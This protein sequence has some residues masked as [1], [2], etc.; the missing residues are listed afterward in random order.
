MANLQQNNIS[1]TKIDPVMATALLDA[2]L[3]QNQTA[4]KLGV[5]PSSISRFC[6]KYD[7]NNNKKYLDTIKENIRYGLIDN[8]DSAIELKNRTINYFCKLPDTEF[9]A[10]PTHQ[11]TALVNAVNPSIGIDIEKLRL[12]DGQATSITG[13]EGLPDDGLLAKMQS[14]LD[15]ATKIGIRVTEIVGEIPASLRDS[16]P[17]LPG[18]S[19]DGLINTE[20]NMEAVGK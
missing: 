2:G 3:S 6:Q 8:I 15:K 13:Y 14:L 17:K 19:H 7:L 18:T 16:I 12:I 9:E 4:K 5:N 10:I 1:C 11:K 20:H